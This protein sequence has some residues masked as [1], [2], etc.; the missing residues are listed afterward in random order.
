M[1]WPFKVF[2][3][4]YTRIFFYLKLYPNVSLRTKTVSRG[5]HHFLE[6]PLLLLFYDNVLDIS[7]TGIIAVS[8]LPLAAGLRNNAAL[9]YTVHVIVPAPSQLACSVYIS[10]IIPFNSLFFFF[11]AD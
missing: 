6:I 10:E 11:A 7:T 3:M 1:A 4:K 5:G 8:Q 9:L 2:L